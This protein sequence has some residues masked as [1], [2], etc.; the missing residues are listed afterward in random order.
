[1]AKLQN[2]KVRL[3]TDVEKMDKYD[4]TLAHLFTEKRNISICNW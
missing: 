4:R 1:M 2:S 3:E